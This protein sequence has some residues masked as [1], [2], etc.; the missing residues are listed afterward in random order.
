MGDTNSKVSRTQRREN[1]ESVKGLIQEPGNGLT[2]IE[3][4][5]LIIFITQL[6]K[7]VDNMKGSFKTTSYALIAAITM[8]CTPL[9][10]LLDNDPATVFSI[11]VMI[12]AFIGAVALFKQGQSSRDKDVSTETEEKAGTVVR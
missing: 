9:L 3:R 12:S 11:E 8:I 5:F 2:W 7:K 1:R 6:I 10:P 4:Q